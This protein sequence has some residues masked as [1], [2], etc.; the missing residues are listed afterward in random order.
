MAVPHLTYCGPLRWW[1][2][3]RVRTG[4]LTDYCALRTRG[5]SA[6]PALCGN[7]PCE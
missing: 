2:V 3:F 4:K 5:A 7:A 6:V 1:V